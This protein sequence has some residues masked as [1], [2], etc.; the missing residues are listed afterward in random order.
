MAQVFFPSKESA[1][2]GFFIMTSTKIKKGKCIVKLQ[3]LS[4]FSFWK[5][6][7][8]LTSWKNSM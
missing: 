4:I 8:T 5:E 6:M 2:N 7:L 1:L 3:I